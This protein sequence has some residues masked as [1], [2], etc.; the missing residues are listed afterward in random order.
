MFSLS[1]RNICSQVP[2]ASITIHS[3]FYIFRSDLNWGCRNLHTLRHNFVVNSTDE[4]IMQ[5]V[6]NDIT[7]IIR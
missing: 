7:Y 6:A 2:D 3:I 4:L 5:A 1:H